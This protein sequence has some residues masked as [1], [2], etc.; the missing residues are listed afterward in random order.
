[1]VEP[2]IAAELLFRGNTQQFKY[3]LKVVLLRKN[4]GNII[5]LYILL[6]VSINNIISDG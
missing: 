1:M 3:K 4:K 5:P 2:F 6:C